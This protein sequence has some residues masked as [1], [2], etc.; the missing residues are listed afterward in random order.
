MF[1]QPN[2]CCP[3]D[4]EPPNEKSRQLR[5]Q[6]IV[7]MIGHFIFS[8]VKL[9]VGMDCFTDIFC[10]IILC[11]A[12]RPMNFC[13]MAL[14][15][16]ILLF[17]LVYAV[18]ALGGEAQS[19]VDFTNPFVAVGTAIIGASMVFYAYACLVSF[20]AY[21]EYKALLKEGLI[22]NAMN[23]QFG[24]FGGGM[25]GFGGGRNMGNQEMRGNFQMNQLTLY[26]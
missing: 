1:G 3:P 12:F 24:G 14:Y 25:R 8:I 6:F 10:A 22:P 9:V 5:T 7:L 18:F 16:I 11:C 2:P 23:G 15:S 17:N 20:Y 13:L 26:I 21:R 4:V 19:E